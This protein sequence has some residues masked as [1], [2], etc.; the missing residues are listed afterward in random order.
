MS[1]GYEKDVLTKLE[2]NFES[3]PVFDNTETGDMTERVSGIKQ[4]GQMHSIEYLYAWIKAEAREIK[5]KIY[6]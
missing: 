1:G 5:V 6:H 3:K 4:A 2:T